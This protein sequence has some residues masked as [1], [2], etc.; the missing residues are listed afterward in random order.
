MKS[1]DCLNEICNLSKE[2]VVSKTLKRYNENEASWKDFVSNLE[3]SYI[4]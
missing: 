4:D 3:H 1:F 2:Y